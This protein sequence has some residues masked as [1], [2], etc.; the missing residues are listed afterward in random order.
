MTVWNNAAYGLKMRGAPRAQIR[1]VVGHY[2][3]R[4]GLSPFAD[5]SHPHLAQTPSQRSASPR[6]IQASIHGLAGT[7]GPKG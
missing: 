2:L 5:R 1:E 4:T 7:R 3:D 6:L